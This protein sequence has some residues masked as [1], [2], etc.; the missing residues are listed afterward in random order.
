MEFIDY[1]KILEVDKNASE[2]DIKKA[3]RKLA[4]KYHPDLNP[5]DENA[6]KKFQQIN[7]ANEVLGDKEKRK[8]F[9]QY[10]KDWKHAEEFEKADQQRGQRPPTNGQSQQAWSGNDDDYSDFFA[11]MFG[12][13]GAGGR[14]SQIKFRGQDFSATLNLDIKDVYQKQQQT[15]TVNGKNIRLT[16]P[17]G[18]EHGQTIKIAGHGGDGVN[19]G[20]RGDLLLTFHIHNNTRFKREGSNLHSDVE[21][22]LYTAVLGGEITTDTFDGKVKLKVK[23][24]TQSGTKVKLAGKGFPVYKKEGEFGD[25]FITF[26]VKTPTD[27]TA[28]ERELFVQLSKLHPHE[29]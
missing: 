29:N 24:G 10:G 28:E 17:A 18:V 19:G 21:I 5:N 26:K 12:G 11:S 16:I 27:L 25:L 13:Q 4:R 22:D 20:P 2:D 9:D 8:K 7:E 1:Y 15:L 23:E 14:N 3:Y 6:K